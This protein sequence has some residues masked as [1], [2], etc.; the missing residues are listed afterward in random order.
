[1]YVRC[2]KY[3]QIAVVVFIS[4]N[5]F[6]Q[7]SIADKDKIIE[8]YIEDA[9]FNTETEIDYNIFLE[10]L[11]YFYDNPINL[12]TATKETLERLKLLNW[13]Q[14]LNLH[15]Y[16]QTYG[17]LV[18]IYELKLINGFT[19]DI[20]EDILPFVTVSKDE[21]EMK[22]SLKNAFTMGKHEIF[23]RGQQVIERQ[24]GYS[25]ISDSALASNVNSRYLGSPQKLY[26]KYNYKYKYNV[27]WGITAEKDAG[28]QLFNGNNKNGFDYYSA[29]LFIKDVK[30]IK[31]LAFGDYHT[32]FGQ[33]LIMCSDW[34]AGKSSYVLNIGNTAQGLTKYSSTDENLFFRGIGTTVRIKNIDITGFYSQKKIDG[35]LILSDSLSG[36][37][38]D[39]YEITSFQTTG[40]HTTVG[41]FADK[42]TI[43]E[44]I[45]GGNIKY[46]HDFFQVGASFLHYDYN[47]DVNPSF[48]LYNKYYFRG[49]K[50]SD[51][52]VDYKIAYNN[53]VLFGEEAMSQNKG[54]AFLNGF[55]ITPVSSISF[56]L[57]HR[58]YS[59]DYQANYGKSFSV[60]DNRN[61]K[62]LFFGTKF[63]PYKNWTVSAYYDLYSFPW[64]K[65]SV[66]SPSKGNDYLLQTT[67]SPSQ[68]VEM[69]F[70]IRQRMKQEDNNTT[71]YPIS[72][73][74]DIKTT[75]IRYNISYR[76]SD[77]VLL[78]NRIEYVICK[79]TSEKGFLLYQDI[80][81]SPL[82]VPFKAS[83]RYGVF[84]TDSYS[85]SV[86]AYESDVLYSASTT[87]YYYKGTRFYIVLQYAIKKGI[88]IWVRYSQTYF[89]G[90]QSISSGL[91]EI[92]GNTKSEIKVM[93]RF[94][95]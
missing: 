27:S 48:R 36:N 88:D 11:Y 66:S 30:F 17:K 54:K 2:F 87:A 20:I 15:N 61:E 35:N 77:E 89:S 70:K 56:S 91:T 78:K 68:K 76:V 52:S 74:E 73:L 93:M 24:T 32:S 25:S 40:L 19:T 13:F 1:M 53:I 85:A 10:D 59:V 86:Y 57:L 94:Q 75:Q 51:Y 23:I 64:L 69:Y 21:N 16:I 41:G 42:H 26:F 90:K 29:H 82:K 45:A 4:N 71:E 49:N 58:I 34:I 6:S 65:F 9:Y 67:Y 95:F 79:N 47:Y 7:E 43:T 83:F 62:G 39:N 37:S 22:Y 72:P 31:K 80:T 33:G 81:Y 5:S 50:N 84:D 55:T 46:N 38:N 44:K 8:S 28:E 14:I 3:F 92:N 12:N 63:Y 18:S 60:S